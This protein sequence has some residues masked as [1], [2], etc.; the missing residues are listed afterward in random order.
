MNGLILLDKPE[1]ITSFGATCAIKK[2]FNTKRVGHT[3]TLDPLATGVLPILVGRATR[4]ATY[5]CEADKRYTATLKLGITTDTQDITGEIIKSNPTDVS[6]QQFLSAI[7]RFRG[8]IMQKPPMYSAIR[9]DGVRL[10]SLAR[11]GIEIERELRPI[12]IKEINLLEQLSDTE[13]VIDVLCSKGTYIRTLI[14]DI[15]ALLGC[16]ATMTALRRTMTAGFSIDDCVKLESLRE[17]PDGNIL[18]ADVAVPDFENVFVSSAQGKRFL[19]GGELSL[20]RLTLPQNP[21]ELLKIYSDD[22]FLGLGYLSEN[23]LKVKCIVAE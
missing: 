17:N 16:G 19:C 7:E 18:S 9:K 20:Q 14:D 5:I 4:L 6:R 15:G 3:G 12:I 22:L 13:Y 21:T 10:Y 8:E 11:Q 1:G 23:D 2:I